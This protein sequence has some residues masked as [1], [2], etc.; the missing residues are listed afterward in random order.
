MRGGGGGGG[1]GG[2]TH[3]STE[4]SYARTIVHLTEQNQEPSR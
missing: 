1:G 2:N 4:F 3:K